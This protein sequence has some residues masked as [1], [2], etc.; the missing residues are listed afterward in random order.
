MLQIEKILLI[1]E[2]HSV[3]F[4][5][6]NICATSCKGNNELYQSSCAYH[7]KSAQCLYFKVKML[8]VAH[9]QEEP[10]IIPNYKVLG[11]ELVSAVL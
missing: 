6:Q 7:F 4:L 2:L 1:T 8:Q 5:R 10:T 11:K 9:S 3:Y